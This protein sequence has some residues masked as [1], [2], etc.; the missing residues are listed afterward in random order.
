[1]SGFLN[2][3]EEVTIKNEVSLK[4]LNILEI[5]PDGT[6]VEKGDLLIELDA[7]P[8]LQEKIRIETLV[9]DMAL[10]L[11]EAENT[12]SITES[13]VKSEL[14]SSENSIE[15]AR[16]DL[17][18]FKTLDK[19]R[20]LDE[21]LHDI[22]IAKDELNLSQQGY[23][24]SVELAEKGFETKSKVDRDKLD[25]SAKEK[26]LKSSIA[27]H[28]MLKAYDLHKEDLELTKQLEESESKYQ[29]A[30]KEGDNKKHKALAKLE[31]AKVKL[32]RA[33]EE[34][35]GVKEQIAKTIIH[36]PLDG[37]A[38]YPNVSR[39]QSSNK[40]EK[41]KSVRLSESLIRIP[42]MSKM[43][44]DIEVAEHFVSDLEVGQKVIVTIDS[45]KDREFAGVL[46]HVALLPIK[47]SSYRRGGVQKYKVV[48]DIEDETLP[49][50]IKPQISAS[51]EIILDTLEDVVFVPIQAVHTVKGKRVVYIKKAG[52]SDYEMREVV[53][54]KMDASYLQISEGLAEGDEVL[55]SEPQI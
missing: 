15:F 52:S 55:I 50:S 29:R 42:N 17:E 8:L 5:I 16:L 31:N 47:E 45:L 23:Q 51:T 43:K 34:L 40:I 46:G 13:E 28:K 48:V 44:V 26:N 1:E 6:L 18:R 33:E 2:A 24:A 22:D 49:D 3:V 38:L 41:G 10:A 37:Y 39:Y 53:I 32:Q 30:E 21:A 27:K 20:Q 11:T 35:A 9:G 14:S 25:L 36:A 54:G 4:S 12:Y 19:V 7:E